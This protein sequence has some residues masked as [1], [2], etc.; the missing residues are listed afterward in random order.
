MQIHACLP[1]A[2]PGKGLCGS[3]TVFFCKPC[4]VSCLG[5]SLCAVL[6]CVFSALRQLAVAGQCGAQK[7]PCPLRVLV[8]AFGDRQCDACA[9]GPW[10]S[11]VITAPASLSVSYS[12]VRMRCGSWGT[13]ALLNVVLGVCCQASCRGCR[14][15]V[16]QHELLLVLDCCDRTPVCRD[17][18]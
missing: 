7:S 6:G 3:C 5:P 13:W 11:D 9:V 12:F 1:F 15:L 14:S 16:V 17:S 8:S 18:S 4:T 10:L 2:A